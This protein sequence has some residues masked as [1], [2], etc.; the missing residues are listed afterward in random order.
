MPPVAVKQISTIAAAIANVSQE[1]LAA[2][3]ATAAS[4]GRS[5]WLTGAACADN[6]LEGAAGDGHH[7]RKQRR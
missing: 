1:R 5:P 6:G 4:G 2:R 7:G 3:V